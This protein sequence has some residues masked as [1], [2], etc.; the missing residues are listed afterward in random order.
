M[1]VLSSTPKPVSDL[2]RPPH[3]PEKTIPPHYFIPQMCQNLRS[4][5]CL[6]DFAAIHD[7][8]PPEGPQ[9]KLKGCFQLDALFLLIETIFP[10]FTY[11]RITMDVIKQ[12]FLFVAHVFHSCVKVAHDH[13]L[14]V[15]G[16][17][18]PANKIETSRNA[19]CERVLPRS[20]FTQPTALMLQRGGGLRF[21]AGSPRS[22][23]WLPR[24]ARSRR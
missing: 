24:K 5:I 16:C 3:H 15:I 21:T 1:T 4:R 9:A 7:P 17:T 6:L 22:E 11:Q 8:D 12:W 23:W 10:N 14:C 13:C 18:V 20:G 2:C 19:W